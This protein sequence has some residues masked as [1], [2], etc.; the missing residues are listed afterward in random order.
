MKNGG[1]LLGG[2][3]LGA[4]V[5]VGIG[6]LIGVDSEKKKQWLKFISAKVL[7]RECCCGDDCDCDEEKIEVSENKVD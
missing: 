6:Y 2:L 5:G 3:A 1:Q 7:R 4:L